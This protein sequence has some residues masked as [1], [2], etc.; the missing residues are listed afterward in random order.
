MKKIST[1]QWGRYKEH[2]GKFVIE[3]FRKLVEDDSFS[4]DLA[5]DLAKRYDRQVFVNGEDGYAEYVYQ[6]A[7]II[8]D[9]INAI[10]ESN[11]ELTF[12]DLYIHLMERVTN[13]LTDSDIPFEE[14]KE[15]DFKAFLSL[16]LIVSEILYYFVPQFFIPNFFVMQFVNLK[17]IAETYEL[18]LPE[19]P[20]RSRYKERCMYYLDMCEMLQDFA[21][22]NGLSSAELCAFLYDYEASLIN[23]ENESQDRSELPEAAQA[24]FL[25]GNYSD[26]ESS[27][28]SG[29]WQANAETKRGDIM[30]FYEKAP[31]K[32]INSYWRATEDGVVDPFFFFYSNTYI[33][34]KKE[35]PAISLDELR[36]DVYFAKHPL[37]HKNFQGGSGWPLTSEDYANLKRMLEAKG[38]DTS[39]MPAL[40][41]HEIPA[42]VDLTMGGTLKPEDG[43]HRVLVL[44]LLEKMGWT[45]Q[46]GSVIGQVPYKIGRGEARTVGR[47]DINL[48]P[49]GDKKAKVIIEEKALMNNESEISDAFHQGKSYAMLANAPTMVICDAR[50]IRVYIK[51]KTDFDETKPIIFYWDEMGNS[52]KFNELK[53]LLK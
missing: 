25:V 45:E 36:E 24:W 3:Q 18:E 1:S 13:G 48:H 8:F 41:A 50:Q 23:E 5:V 16:N 42:D 9:E 4:I 38:Y 34:D 15:G 19:L 31:A 21:Q 40:M 6:V 44:P 46:N 7:P 10:F 53:N 11:E 39:S 51:T 47:T 17:K 26:E 12:E 33:A 32:S 35:I 2:D 22:E 43:V 30:V 28:Q 29:F 14:R 52:D 27:M 37:I 49:Y 20:K